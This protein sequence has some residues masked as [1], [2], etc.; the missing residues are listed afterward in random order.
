MS[1]VVID[2]VPLL[3][4]FFSTLSDLDFEIE[5]LRLQ[6]QLRL[7]QQRPNNSTDRYPKH[8]SQKQKGFQTRNFEKEWILVGYIRKNIR[9][10]HAN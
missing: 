5:M 2:Y 4:S 3:N 10:K 6:T 8:S 1:S 9:M 7:P